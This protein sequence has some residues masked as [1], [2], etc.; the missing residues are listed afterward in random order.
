MDENLHIG[1]YVHVEIDPERM[2][3]FDTVSGLRL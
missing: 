2:Y 3:F 1:Q